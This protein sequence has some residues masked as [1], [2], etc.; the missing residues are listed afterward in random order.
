MNE[1][2]PAPLY[3]PGLRLLQGLV[4]ALTVSMILGVVTVVALLFVRLPSTTRPLPALP[5]SVALPDGATAAAITFGPG[6]FGVVTDTGRMLVFGADGALL[7][8][9]D[10]RAR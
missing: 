5:G 9:V 7:R 3:P 8:E 4:I 6:W 2:P 10:V 1:A